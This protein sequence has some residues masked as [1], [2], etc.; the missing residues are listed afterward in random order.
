MINY[1][2]V[3]Y[4]IDGICSVSKHSKWVSIVEVT[5]IKTYNFEIPKTSKLRNICMIGWGWEARNIS[6]NELKINYFKIKI[7]RNTIQ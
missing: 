7:I 5:N 3:Y 6:I 4:D 2:F 1:K